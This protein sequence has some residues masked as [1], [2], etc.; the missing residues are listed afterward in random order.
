MS[1]FKEP[2]R[3]F[4]C[5]YWRRANRIV[6]IGT[7]WPDDHEISDEELL[8]IHEYLEREKREGT[9]NLKGGQ[10]DVS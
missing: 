6:H 5:N 1:R 9:F 2:Y 10:D 8:V 7:R 3:E 4:L